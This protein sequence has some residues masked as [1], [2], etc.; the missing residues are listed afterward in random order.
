MF[1]LSDSNLVTNCRMAVTH[2]KKAPMTDTAKAMKRLPNALCVI[3]TVEHVQ[4]N[5]ETYTIT[6]EERK[7]VKN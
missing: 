7:E 3:Y 2:T 4:L 5:Q 6:V 1:S